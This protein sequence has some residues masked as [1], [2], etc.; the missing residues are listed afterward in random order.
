MGGLRPPIK[1]SLHQYNYRV[2]MVLKKHRPQGG[3]FCGYELTLWAEGAA[4]VLP[5]P[6]YSHRRIG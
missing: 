3:A 4:Y 1:K 6:M 5:C 2:F